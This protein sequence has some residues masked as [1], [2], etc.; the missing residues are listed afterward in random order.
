MTLHPPRID[1]SQKAFQLNL[2]NTVYGTLAEIGAGQEA[3]RWFFRVGGAAGTIAKTMSA[4]DMDVSDAIYGP[5][6][7]Y[8]SQQRL[9]T[10]LDREFELLIQRLQTQR[11]IDSRFFAYANTVA[12][13][14]FKRDADGHGWM[15]IRF[16]HEPA[17]DP[18]DVIIH[19]R[20]KDNDVNR[21]QDAV[22][23]L[24]IN[25]IFGATKLASRPDEFLQSLMDELTLDRVEIDMIRMSGP[26][27]PE[28]DSRLI[29]LKLVEFGLTRS[30]MFTASG[31]VVQ[32]TEMLY[33]KPVLV[34]RGTFQTFSKLQL[35]RL[36]AATNQF[37]H[38]PRNKGQEPV[39]LLEMNLK[40]LPSGPKRDS[41][42]FLARAEQLR[43]LGHPVLITNY[44]RHLRLADYLFKATNQMVGIVMSSESLT[45]LFK[46]DYYTDLNGGIFESFGRMFKNDLVVYGYSARGEDKHSALCP[47]ELKVAPHLRNLYAHLLENRN[48]VSLAIP[49]ADKADTRG[50]T[51]RTALSI[52]YTPWV[53]D[54]SAGVRALPRE[55]SLPQAAPANN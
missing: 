17:A 27:F 38:E 39:V 23:V 49:A 11:D 54:T 43:K 35:D 10:M 52:D 28:L 45:E 48:I 22:G 36:D 13:R 40:N 6:P 32:P 53:E 55:E 9:T 7:R 2:D 3:A 12:T 14:S 18:S 42:D 30:A 24:G 29:A 37:Q 1:T 26:A 34:K 41:Q 46:E 16:Q 4:Y 21:Q 33:K 19:V 47:N 50:N 8:V 25:L 20:L 44:Y 15:G 31:D 5:T 51:Q